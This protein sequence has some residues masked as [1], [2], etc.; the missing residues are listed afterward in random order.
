MS[1]ITLAQQQKFSTFENT[2]T[3]TFMK[4][5]G[6]RGKFL[7]IPLLTDKNCHRGNGNSRPVSIARVT[8]INQ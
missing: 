4:K 8:S 7:L 3:D 6:Q 1:A 2:Q 5:R